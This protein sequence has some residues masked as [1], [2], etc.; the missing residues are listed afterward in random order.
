MRLEII[1]ATNKHYKYN[2]VFTKKDKSIKIV[3]FGDNRYQDYTQHHDKKRRELYLARHRK[4]ENWNDPETAGSLS[5]YILWG[6]SKN[7]KPIF[8]HLRID[9]V[10]FRLLV[11]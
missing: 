9:L 2:A 8:K 5:R 10:I 3:P 4:N 6:E 1:P 7:I 11:L